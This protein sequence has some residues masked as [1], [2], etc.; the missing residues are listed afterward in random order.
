MGKQ[1]YYVMSCDDWKSND[2]M[3][4]RL[5]TTD[6]EKLRKYLRKQ[7]EDQEFIY[8]GD[9]V[10]EQ[11]A[12]FDEDWETSNIADINSL[13]EFGCYSYTYDGEEI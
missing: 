4:L 2:S 5:V 1:I 11:L 10:E 6:E 13:L 3:R 7:I 12:N 8:N 9:T